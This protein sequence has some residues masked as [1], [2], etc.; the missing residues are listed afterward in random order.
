MLKL[1]VHH[2]NAAEPRR[3]LGGARVKRSHTLRVYRCL[4]LVCK[5]PRILFRASHGEF[6]KILELNQGMLGR[7]GTCHEPR[8]MPAA[9]KR[10]SSS[11]ACGRLLLMAA[12]D[13][14]WPHL[15]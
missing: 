12:L 7:L 14:P 9:A 1:D 8:P 2:G 4:R 15:T 10:S 11:A 5:A 6:A 13:A 3:S